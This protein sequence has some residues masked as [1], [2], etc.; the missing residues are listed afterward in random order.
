MQKNKFLFLVWGLGLSVVISAIWSFVWFRENSK[1]FVSV[2][3][4]VYNS[5]KYLEKCLDSLTRQKLKQIEFIVIDDGSTDG[6]YKIMQEFQKK[7]KRFKI[8]SKQNEGVGKTRNRGLKIAKGEYVG[9]VD[10]DD[11][12]SSDYFLKL[13]EK[14]KKWDADVAVA[15]NVSVVEENMIIPKWR[16]VFAYKDKEFLEDF[17]FLIGDAGEQWD[18]IYKM[19]FLEKNYIKSLDGRLWFEDVWF[20]TLVAIYAKRVAISK[21]GRYFYRIREDSLSGVSN[22]TKEEFWK[23]LEIHKNMFLRV[24]NM[25]ISDEEKMDLKLKLR[26]KI[27]WFMGTFG[28]EYNEKEKFIEYF[29][30]FIGL[31]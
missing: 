13:Y 15:W 17:S 23:G 19:S 25:K 30:S 22:I 9:Y 16:P 7:D 2:I 4:P 1:V 31:I 3:V 29:N 6:S 26:E 18:K 28:H 5:E 10:S 20:S 21:E 12:V 27:Y 8:F 14:A 11:F 24:R